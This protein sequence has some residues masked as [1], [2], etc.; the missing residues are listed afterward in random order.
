MAVRHLYVD[1]DPEV[2]WSVLRDPFRYSE[3]VVGTFRSHPEEGHWPD[4]GSSI[5]YEV[6]L[7]PARMRGTTV[8]RRHEHPRE[9]EL[10]AHAGRLGTARIA[11][12]IR[13]WGDGTLIIVD[14][15]PL[16]GFGGAAH[17]G[18]SDRL[19][20]LRHRRMLARLGRVVEAMP[21]SGV[22]AGA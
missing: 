18:V 11:L 1:R 8:C 6:R 2:L 19:I 12:D 7:G 3:W 14:E 4:V 13:P 5:A 17:N 21:R 22:P 16:R 9:L 15:H 10:E 20:Q